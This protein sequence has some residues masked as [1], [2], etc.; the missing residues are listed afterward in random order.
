VLNVLEPHIV[1]DDEGV[2]LKIL[3]AMNSLM[4]SPLPLHNELLARVCLPNRRARER[5]RAQEH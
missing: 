2:E 4:T 1:C 5:D 3:Q